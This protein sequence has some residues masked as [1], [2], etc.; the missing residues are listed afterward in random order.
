MINIS[1][2]LKFPVGFFYFSGWEALFKSLKANPHVQIKLLVSLQVGR[3]LQQIVEQGNQETG[4]SQ[5]NHF[6]RFIT[7]LG[8]AVNN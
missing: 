8:K 5:D 4:M 7:S 6:Q 1:N 2:E 3:L